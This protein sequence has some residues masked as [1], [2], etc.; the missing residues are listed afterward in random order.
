M[1][2]QLVNM[3]IMGFKSSVVVRFGLW[4]LLQGQTMVHWLWWVVFL[5]D[6]VLHCS[7]MRRSSLIWFLLDQRYF[8][9]LI[10]AINLSLTLMLNMHMAMIWVRF[11]FGLGDMILFWIINISEDQPI[12]ISI[13]IITNKY[14]T[15]LPTLVGFPKMADTRLCGCL[16]SSILKIKVFFLCVCAEFCVSFVIIMFIWLAAKA[17]LQWHQQLIDIYVYTKF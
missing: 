5:V 3:E 11:C 7:P 8:S 2:N 15:F 6:A 12:Q 10:H 13:F 9:F 14:V 1:W 17:L 16:S 4:L